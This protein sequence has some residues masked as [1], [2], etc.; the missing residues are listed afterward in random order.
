MRKK[1]NLIPRMERVSALRE[2]SPAENAGQWL[3]KMSAAAQTPLSALYLE[4]GCGKGA[5][6]R[7]LAEENPQ[8]AI[9][10]VEM[11]PEAVVV[12]MERM[13]EEPKAANS[14]FILGDARGLAEF[15]AAGE[16]DRIY[17]NFSDPWHKARH[18]KRRLTSPD[19]LALYRRILAPGGEILF[20]TD[21][22]PLFEYSLETFPAAQFTL[23]FV[24]RNL[25]ENGIAELM[26]DYETKF[27]A[28]GVP[29]N[30][31]IARNTA[32]ISANPLENTQ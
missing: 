7:R 31:L 29:I 30:K 1:P 21:N 25:H 17:I 20:K 8:A 15:F 12:A 2:D 11:S 10:A 27:H 6:T 26:T 23:E 14:R 5:F 22:V 19:F 18:A 16:V 9:V 3:A 24:T 4:L 13:L 28:A 32:G